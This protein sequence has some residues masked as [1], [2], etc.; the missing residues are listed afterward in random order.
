MLE[1]YASWGTRASGPL[2][3]PPEIRREARKAP[4]GYAVP[5]FLHQ[6][7][8]EMDIVLRHQHRAKHLAGLDQMMQIGAAPGPAYGTSAARIEDR[9]SVVEGKRVSRRVHPGGRSVYKKKKK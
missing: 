4:G 1:R 3:I 9:K 2:V 5:D 6:R 7:L 8:V